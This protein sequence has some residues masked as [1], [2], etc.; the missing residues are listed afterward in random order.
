M[1]WRK[2][3]V[4]RQAWWPE[5]ALEP[6]RGSLV[7]ETWTEDGI[8]MT[9]TGEVT[10]VERDRLLKFIWTEPGWPSSLEV[11]FRLN[12][13]GS[14]TRLTITGSGFGQLNARTSLPVEHGQGWH[15]H[16]TRLKR[17]C[18]RPLESPT[19]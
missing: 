14:A 5:L 2:L 15:H 11:E 8:Q 19:N 3:T 18:E 1:V 12:P 6:I 16:A 10:R 9:A 4:D 13:E 17:E 7:L